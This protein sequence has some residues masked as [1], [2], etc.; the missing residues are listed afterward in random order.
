MFAS[1]LARIGRMLG[2]ALL[3]ALAPAAGARA[4]DAAKATQ[5]D[6]PPKTRAELRREKK[7]EE[8]DR[9]KY[10][11]QPRTAEVFT[12]VREHLAADRH[13]KA[14]AA[15]K[16]LARGKLSPYERAQV[17]RL[18]GYVYYG[19]Q[20]N[21]AAIEHLQKALAEDALPPEDRADIL[22]QI[23]QIQ[24]VEKRWKD[25][26]A[27]LDAWFS[28]AP[29]P[30]SVGYYLMALSHYQLQDM[31]GA[32]A[33]ARQAVELAQTP[34]QA[35]LQLLLAIHLSRK[36]YAAATPV[37]AKLISYYPDTG[38]GYWLQLSALYGVSGDNPRA[39]AVM[40][41]AYRKNLLSDDRDLIRLVQLNLLQGI[42]HRAALILEREM[43]AKRIPENA[44]AFEL[45]S[46]SFILAREI[47]KAEAPLAR[48]AELAPKGDLFVRLAQ[49]HMMQEE[50]QD[51]AKALQNALAKGGL[52]DAANAE[53]LLGISYYNEKQL[54]EAR[55]W[56]ARA[57]K[58]STTRSQAKTW[59]EH[60]DREVAAEREKPQIAG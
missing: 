42:P 31:E 16:K 14:E 6:E 20:Q 44:E 4:A 19:K 8:E 34:Q 26:I 13:A 10:A 28:A 50:W 48:A 29:K 51:A 38:K 33:P 43:A 35:W 54:G 27:T 49:I 59:L 18:F 45:L 58:S 15:L 5:A 32:V 47:A 11:L 12:E 53:L 24:G 57:Q 7:Q 3:L 2:V 46:G 40:E 52:P 37:L 1:P 23:A 60:I 56:F 21:G 39:L 25:V 17:E 55:T 9:K 30:N 41:L 22:F 36:D